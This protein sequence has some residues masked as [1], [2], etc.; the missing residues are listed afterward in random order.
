MK[1]LPQAPD[2]IESNLSDAGPEVLVR[3]RNRAIT[4]SDIEFIKQQIANNP[5]WGRTVLSRHLC[6][7]WNWRQPSGSL[8]EYPCRDL[9]LRLEEWGHLQL[10]KPQKRNG[11]KK[12]AKD[13]PLTVC[14]EPFEN[15]D[16][17]QLSIKLVDTPQDRMVWRALVDRYHYL[18]EGVMCGE[19]LLYL[20]YVNDRVVAALGWGSASLRNPKR[21][22]YLGWSDFTITKNNLHLVTNNLR[23]L[24]LP[25]IKIKNLGS[26]ILSLNIKRLNA[27][28][29][30]RYHHELICVETYVDTTL[31][32][33]TVYKAANWHYL[34]LSAGRGKQGNNYV[35]NKTIKAIYVLKIKAAGKRQVKVQA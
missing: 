4:Q 13:L 22:S 10:P 3:Y 8:K 29:M 30:N 2:N 12:K 18:G 19:H 25:W 21:D 6:E 9:L 16:P 14:E 24:I 32:H 33:G 23:F 27:D 34:G 5:K 17:S 15:Y 31:Y 35:N 26:R 7:V 11:Q 1:D 28:W 20:V